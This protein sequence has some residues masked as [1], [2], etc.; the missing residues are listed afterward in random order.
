MKC[1]IRNKSAKKKRKM[2]DVID[3]GI[4]L[5]EPLYFFD[6]IYRKVRIKVYQ[7]K[8]AFTHACECS[9]H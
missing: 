4:D 7:L 1:R 9:F 2:F 6:Q 5:V 3:N 8:E